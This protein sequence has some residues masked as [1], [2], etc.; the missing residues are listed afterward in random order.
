MKRSMKIKVAIVCLT[1]LIYPKS[2]YSRNNDFGLWGGFN[3]EYAFSRK[4]DFAAA[5]MVRSFDNATKIEQS[6]FELGAYYRL[7]K[8]F[9]VGGL[10]RFVSFRESDTHYHVRNKLL[11]DIKGA[12][13]AGNFSFSSRFRLE[14]TKKTFFAEG[15]DR[16]PDFTL[17]LKFKALYKFP[18]FPV[19]PYLGIETFSTVVKS[20]DKMIDKARDSFGLEFRLSK[21][22]SIVTEYLFQKAYSKNAYSMNIVSLSYNLKF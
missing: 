13:P 12:Y 14:I 22:N 21:H 18:E 9:S 20:S 16:S 2:I 5:G 19:Y 17:R 3:A 8:Y 1:L 6:Y 7:C 11:A 10:Y 4:V 15:A